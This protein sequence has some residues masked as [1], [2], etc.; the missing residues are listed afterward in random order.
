M[1]DIDN[2][3]EIIQIGEK[4]FNMFHYNS[5]SSLKSI[6]KNR[7]LRFT[8]RR[9]LND[10]NKFNCSKEATRYADDVNSI[11]LNFCHIA[12]KKCDGNGARHVPIGSTLSFFKY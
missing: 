11:T 3:I 2:K 8:K 6:T 5:I 1:K 9:F 7:S 12:E 4:E 10:K